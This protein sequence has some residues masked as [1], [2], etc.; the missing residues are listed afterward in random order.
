M[1]RLVTS[2]AALVGLYSSG[3]HE[4]YCD[5]PQKLQQTAKDT[6]IVEKLLETFELFDSDAERKAWAQKYDPLV[7]YVTK[8]QETAQR[9]WKLEMVQYKHSHFL[10]Y[11]RNSYKSAGVSVT[12]GSSV[13]DFSI[14]NEEKY[15]YEVKRKNVHLMGLAVWYAKLMHEH[16][17]SQKREMVQ[18]D[19]TFKMYQQFMETHCDS[20][21][22]GKVPRCFYNINVPDSMK[23]FGLRDIYGSYTADQWNQFDYVAAG[24]AQLTENNLKT[25]N[26]KWLARPWMKVKEEFRGAAQLDK[27]TGEF[28]FYGYDGCS[29]CDVLSDFLF[30]HHIPFVEREMGGAP[31]QCS[32][33]P[34]ILDG[35]NCYGAGGVVIT[36][37]VKKMYDF[38]QP[39]ASEAVPVIPASAEP[40][41]KKKRFKD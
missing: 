18:G 38:T 11:G 14:Y 41:P 8:Y 39:A 21:H 31:G 6:T 32:G 12:V 27:K 29:N 5:E 22:N 9:I 2:L 25:E 24:L 15:S 10:A 33:A 3:S 19:V 13:V 17:D 1:R 28:V 37:L 36:D 40:V 4:G 35:K 30:D 26:A 34:Y 20:A 16:Y 7:D 23:G